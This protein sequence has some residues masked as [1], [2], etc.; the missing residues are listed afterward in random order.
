[1]EDVLARDLLIISVGDLPAAG[2]M[3]WPKVDLGAPE[4]LAV[5]RRLGLQERNPQLVLIGKDGGVKARQSGVF[6]LGELLALIDTM[7]VRRAEAH[8]R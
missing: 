7:P 6:D 3:P 4:R 8:R 5:R 1:M 2:H